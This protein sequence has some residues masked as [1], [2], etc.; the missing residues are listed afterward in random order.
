[1]NDERY[2]WLGGVDAHVYAQYCNCPV[3]YLTATNSADYDC[4]RGVDTLSRV[5]EKI[6]CS[7]NY[8][9]RLC[10]TIDK[11]SADDV[12]L[13][14]KKYITKAGSASDRLY[15][16]ESPSLSLALAEDG[17]TVFAKIMLSESDKLKNLT[18]YLSEGIYDPSKRNWCQ[19]SAVKANSTPE[20]K[21][22][23]LPLG[24]GSNFV[25]AFA[26]ADYKNG[27]IAAIKSLQGRVMARTQGRA[28]PVMT[29]R[30]LKTL[31][32]EYEVEQHV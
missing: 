23:K 7:F 18:V 32:A 8:T 30:L 5:N 25:H 3:L 11:K 10:Q 29:E 9:P 22:F 17:R 16:P 26:V 12:A 4:E 14:L 6:S 13:F 15:F 19:M 21:Y 2:R 20:C 27:K 24:G 31:L 28:D 1:M